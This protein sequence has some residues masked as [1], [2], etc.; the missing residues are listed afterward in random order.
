MS[1]PDLVR[2]CAAAARSLR[3][4]PLAAQDTGHV[5]LRVVPEDMDVFGH[6]TNARYLSLLNL[7]RGDW[8]LRTGLFKVALKRRA[9]MLAG[10][11]DVTYLA[12]LR[13]GQ[14]VDIATRA[15]HW[16]EK[17]FFLEHRLTSA[18][19]AVAVACAKVLF[20]GPRGNVAPA[21]MLAEAGQSPVSPPMSEALRIWSAQPVER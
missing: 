21:V 7:G 4:P 18:D 20:R 10:R 8:A 5:H 19:A 17:W 15:L 3:A 6:V 11:I 1:L 13:L 9:P 12:P 14:R 2:L 16:N